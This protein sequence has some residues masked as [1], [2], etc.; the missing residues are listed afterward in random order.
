MWN[1][2]AHVMFL[3]VIVVVYDR[4][5]RFTLWYGKRL[6]GL[7]NSCADT[8]QSITNGSA[9]RRSE[10]TIVVR[11]RGTNAVTYSSRCGVNENELLRILGDDHIP[12]KILKFMNI[13]DAHHMS[14]T[15][16]V[17]K[18]SIEKYECVSCMHT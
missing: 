5:L 4:L 1:E 3:L 9:P 2:W 10:F 13:P 18:D 8:M 15:V 12:S 14:H 7:R 17:Y 11:E 16:G 6:R